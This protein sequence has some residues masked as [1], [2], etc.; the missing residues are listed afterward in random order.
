MIYPQTKKF[1]ILVFNNQDSHSLEHYKSII[2]KSEKCADES[3]LKPE[4]ILFYCILFFKR[5]NLKIRKPL[6]IEI[7]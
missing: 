5:K 2:G 7:T 4:I 1:S 6:F 3:K